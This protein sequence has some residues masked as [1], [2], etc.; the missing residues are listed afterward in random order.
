MNPNQN[1]K[2]ENNTIKEEQKGED[3]QGDESLSNVNSIM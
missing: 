3:S 1:I 2:V